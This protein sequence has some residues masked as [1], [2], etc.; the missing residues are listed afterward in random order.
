MT[1]LLNARQRERWLIGVI[2][3]IASLL[4]LTIFETDRIRRQRNRIKT[5]E[6]AY[7]ESEQKLR[8]MANNLSEVVLAYD[9]DRHLVFANPAVE[10]LTGYSITSLQENGCIN[11]VHPGDKARVLRYWANLFQGPNYQDAEFRLVSKEGQVKWVSATWG[12]ILDEAGR[13]VGVQGSEREITERKQAEEALRE[14]ELRFRKLLEG[15]Q[16]VAIMIDL[17]GCVWFCNDYTLSITGWKAEEV[18]G[19][20][21]RDF[22]DPEY[23]CQLT[24]AKDGSQPAAPQASSEGT[25]LT[26][27]GNRRWIQWNS[28]ALRDAAGRI[29]G[30]ASLGADVTEIQSLRAEAAQRESEANFRNLADTAPVMIWVA[31]Q[32]KDCTFFNKGWLAFT[33]RTMEQERG[34]GWA[35]GV[36]PDDLERC[37]G[38]YSSSFDARQSFHI[39]YRLRRAD[40]EYRWLLD[41]GVPRFTPGGVFSDYIGSCID[42]TDL[43]RAQD[44]VLATQKLESL[45]VLTAGIA[46]DFNNFL[47]SILAQAELAEAEIGAGSSPDE[48]VQSIKV[49]AI[50]AAEVV[51]EL[52]IYAGQDRATLEALDISQLV[53]EML[54]LLK[55][56]ISKHAVL[57]TD[58]GK[59]L[60]AV[61]GNATQIRQVVMNL[62]INA[63]EAIG[64]KAGS[65]NVT[66][67]RVSVR[68]GRGSR[69]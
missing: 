2:G 52:M 47:G 65:I 68:T 69:R 11:L 1:S 50:R 30:F 27:E 64:E 4:G 34:N 49:V 43:K 24:E 5:T 23:L 9:M 16:L 63:S 26:K 22:L 60:P 25:I 39:E 62:I 46:H 32:G 21:A 37:F 42:I 53:E 31:G 8:L 41:S 54:Q 14:S 36:H 66:T 17:D 3:L 19:H 56:S 38:G 33:G 44:E 58:L 28:T 15:V 59:N 10:R 6:R 67:S 12:P 40:G 48:E 57:K 18:V 13:Q 45:R 29:A 35:E 51:R 7:R 55:V 61:L 20:P